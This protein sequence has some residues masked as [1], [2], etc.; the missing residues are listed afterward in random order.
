MDHLSTIRI[1]IDR[2]PEAKNSKVGGKY[3]IIAE[4]EQTGVNRE[5]DYGSYGDEPVAYPKRKEEKPKYK[6]MV[7]FKVCD[8]SAAKSNALKKKIK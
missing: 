1:P 3:R 8:V 5:R 7:E 4:V 6:T 2:I